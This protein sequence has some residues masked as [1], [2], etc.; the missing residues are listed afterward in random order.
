[1]TIQSFILL[2]IMTYYKRVYM[3]YYKRVY[4]L[5]TGN[6]RALLVVEAGLYCYF[7]H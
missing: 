1:M 3:T 2:I 6:Y 5:M 4:I 7:Q